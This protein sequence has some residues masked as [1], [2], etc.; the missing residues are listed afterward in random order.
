MGHVTSAA[1]VTLD[2]KE[3]HEGHVRF[4]QCAFDSGQITCCWPRTS[5]YFQR[6]DPEHECGWT[7]PTWDEEAMKEH[8]VSHLAAEV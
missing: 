5:L 1:L 4:E 6:H 8:A 7:H 3:P 2:G